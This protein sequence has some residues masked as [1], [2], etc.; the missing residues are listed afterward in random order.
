LN[1]ALGKLDDLSTVVNNTL[2]LGT[3]MYLFKLA[4]HHMA[5]LAQR[6]QFTAENVANANTPGF[7]ERDIAPFDVMHAQTRL[8]LR[9]TSPT[10][11]SA[12]VSEVNGFSR[13]STQSWDQSHTGNTV[14]IEKELMKAGETVR[15]MGL[16]SGLTK[17]FHRMLLST[18]KG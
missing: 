12:T 17:A 8:D 6:Q 3:S 2:T 4:G 16:D 15:A 9:Q 10:H 11:L 14:S 7:R 5:W 18:F 13:Q 1:A